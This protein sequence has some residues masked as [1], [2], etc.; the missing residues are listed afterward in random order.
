MKWTEYRHIPIMTTVQVGT[1]NSN[2]RP[3]PNKVIDN[4]MLNK[5]GDQLFNLAGPPWLN[6]RV[7][8]SN[9]VNVLEV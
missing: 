7:E 3:L 9:F 1:Q 4:N 8:T 2:V 5:Q 6:L